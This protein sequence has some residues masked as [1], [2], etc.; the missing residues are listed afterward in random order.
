MSHRL[1]VLIPEELDARIRK[2]AQR[3]RL[4]IGAW[5]RLAVETALQQPTKASEAPSD[6]LARLS[7]LEGPTGTI[8]QMV[9]EIEIGRQ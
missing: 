3:T 7:S 9:S 4:S 5:V 8:K 6:P 2:A 1:Q